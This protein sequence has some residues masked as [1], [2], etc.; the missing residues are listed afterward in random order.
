MKKI[1]R[2][3]K[4]MGRPV[5]VAFARH[6]TWRREPNGLPRIDRAMLKTIFLRC[7]GAGTGQL[8]AGGLAKVIREVHNMAQAFVGREAL[9]LDNA[10][11]HAQ[12]L[13][14]FHDDNEDGL[15]GYDELQH[16]VDDILTMGPAQREAYKARGGFCPDAVR[17]V[18]DV[19]TA[20][21]RPQ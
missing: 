2:E 17:F 14:D 3:V 10:E 4:K 20:L 16:W 21:L 9:P 8:D 15:I 13:I 11:L 12:D 6:K 5:T 1:A 19:A 7:D 18:V